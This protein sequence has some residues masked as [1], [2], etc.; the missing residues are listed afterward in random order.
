MTNNGGVFREEDFLE[1]TAEKYEQLI[2]INVKGVFSGAQTAA[3]RMLE[4]ERSGSIIDLSSVASP[5]GSGDFPTYCSSKGAVQLLTYSLADALG[6]ADIR[7]NAIRPGIIETKMTT[8]DVPIVGTEL[9]EQ[10]L[11][12]VPLH[13]NCQPEDIGDAAMFL[14]S[15]VIGE[16]LVLD[17][18]MS[19]TQ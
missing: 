11:A 12:M 10:L 8:E 17:S 15:Y 19:N 7:V 2:D 16:S 9:G 18:G 13:R 14:A 1:V 4:D 3:K 6:P 5:L